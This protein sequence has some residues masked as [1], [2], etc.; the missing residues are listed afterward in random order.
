MVNISNS[1][2][3][4]KLKSH[5]L[6]LMY[7]NVSDVDVFLENKTICLLFMRE[8]KVVKLFYAEWVTRKT[9]V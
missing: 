8:V 7:P 9:Y 1:Y 6:P 4:N 5:W 2:L 3:K